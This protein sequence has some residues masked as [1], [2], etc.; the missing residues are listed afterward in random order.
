[1]RNVLP[2]TNARDAVGSLHAQRPLPLA[3]GKG[4]DPITPEGL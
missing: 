1:M 3:G 2:A 4:P